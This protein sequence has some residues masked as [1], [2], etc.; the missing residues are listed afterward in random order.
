MK[1]DVIN[2]DNRGNGFEAALSETE[3]AAKYRDLDSKQTLQLRI[4]TE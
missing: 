3:A 2:I 4:L 1:S